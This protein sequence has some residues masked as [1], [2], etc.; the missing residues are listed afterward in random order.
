MSETAAQVA[1]TVKADATTSLTWLQKH[2]RIVIIFL[3]LAAVT[4]L[5]QKY[6]DVRADR[7][8]QA[9]TVATQ[10]LDVQKTQNAQLAVQVG[11]LNN[12]YQALQVQLT[13]ENAQ[14]AAAMSSRVTV[15]HDQQATD[16]TMPLPDLGNR[17]AQLAGIAPTDITAST[18]GI[19]VTDTG[20]RS[21]VSKLE[22]VP[23]L[24]ANLKDSQTIATNRQDELTKANGLIDGLNLQVTNL[25]KTVT[26][27]DTA[28]KA[29][30]A[31]TK[32]EANKSKTKWFKVGFGVGFITGFVVDH[33]TKF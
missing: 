10:Q 19:T 7:D 18:A 3:V 29:E 16:K 23:V 9:A 4:W 28:C 13:Q 24:Q 12:Q 20:A 14:L 17:W 1:T 2:E 32:A 8:K 27:D 11:Q 25:N 21:T 6:L 22:Q 31:S 26:D 5:G 30:I 15:L 33:I